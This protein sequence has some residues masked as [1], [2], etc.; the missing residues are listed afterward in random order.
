MGKLI[1]RGSSGPNGSH[2]LGLHLTCPRLGR[3]EDSD[4]GG[5]RED[6]TFLTRGNLLHVGLAHWYAHLAGWEGYLSPSAAIE[7]YAER[8]ESEYNA[9]W[10][11]RVQACLLAY[12]AFWGEEGGF[13]VVD[14]EKKVSFQVRGPDDTWLPYTARKDLT[15]RRKRD[16]KFFVVDH[17]GTYAVLPK[18][19]KSYALSL[20][21]L[22]LQ[23]LGRAQYGKQFGG[24]LLNFIRIPTDPTKD[25]EFKR[26]PLPHYPKAVA[27][28]KHTIKQ[29]H[30]IRERWAGCDPMEVPGVYQEAC[31]G[32]YGKCS[33]RHECI[34]REE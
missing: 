11:D 24:V 30:T 18:V 19:V 1:D 23:R 9:E 8:H 5:A 29:A 34:G 10:M 26:V 12:A 3:F 17:K 16:G 13:E 27:D 20:Q 4:P 7:A 22:G 21:M 28:V 2:G 15:L 14:I 25:F 6:S 33:R 31:W 32:R